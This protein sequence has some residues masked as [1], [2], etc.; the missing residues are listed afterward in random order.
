MKNIVGT[1]V[2]AGNINVRGGEKTRIH[3]AAYGVLMDMLSGIYENAAEA[4]LREY[5]VNGWDEHRKHGVERPVEVTLPTLLQPTLEI[6]DYARGIPL[7]GVYVVNDNGERV[8]VER[9][10]ME[11]FGEYGNSGKRDSDEEVGGFGIGS[12]AAFALGQ[13]FIVNGY[14]DGHG[15]TVL[16]TLNEDGTGTKTVMWEGPT[17]EPN[18]VKVSLGV[19][20]VEGMRASARRFFSFWNEGDVVVDYGEGFETPA[21][22][23]DT[24][25]QV[26]DEIFLNT[27]GR[28]E[29]YAVMGPVTYPIS[30]HILD[31]VSRYLDDQG[32]GEVSNLPL[33]L[34]DSSTDMYVRVPIGG[35][36][37]APSREA[38]RDKDRTVHTI[39]AVFYGLHQDS[40]VKIQNEV[41]AAPSFFAAARAFEE[42]NESL[43][44]FKVSRKAVTWHGRNIHSQVPVDLVNYHLVQ[45]SWRSDAK[46]V[47]E[48]PH[49]KVSFAQA[50]ASLVITGISEEQRGSVRRFAKRFLESNERGIERIF[51]MEGDAASFEWFQVGVPA[52]VRSVDLD[53]WRAMLREIRKTSPRT[54]NEPS[55]TT[56]FT[57][58]SRDLDD[59]DLLSDIIS[60]GLDIVIFHDSASY[61]NA[62]QREV[63]KNHTVVV[64]LGTQ[65]EDALIKRIEA[66]GSVKIAD[67]D[68]LLQ[69][70]KDNA[71]AVV[72]GVTDV[73]KEALGAKAWLESNAGMRRSVQRALTALGQ[74]GAVTNTALLGVEESFALAE[75]F[76]KPMTETRFKQIALARVAAGLQVR[77][78]TLD[79][80]AVEYQ[81]SVD[82]VFEALPLLEV[83]S[84]KQAA[85]R[86]QKHVRVRPDRTFY[87]VSEYRWNSYDEDSHAR[88]LRYLEH[89]LAYVNQH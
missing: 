52:G 42:T 75:E 17:N 18:G 73:E 54:V 70:A 64:L 30:R 4:V 65:S 51:V 62:Y 83:G 7:E 80:M 50:D 44:A 3:E 82:S 89:S 59:R 12:K 57:K 60:E 81:D 22:V 15:F 14:K 49:A 11:V 8:C 74:V 55:Y 31:K 20:D 53:G 79:D 26:N 35:V 46:V 66:D 61:L 21:S 10:A 23:F 24:L 69:Q 6:R 13:Q 38:L 45:K 28:G 37:P 33:R 39:G 19:E 58:A 25:E 16:F 71:Q 27:H 87:Y 5:S 34:V 78:N 41:D 48:E 9:G 67:K 47:G 84:V 56:G 40:V 68:A 85:D 63:L 29:A 32:M 2:N 86:I 36:I 1:A 43:G 76:A 77:I 72:D 88:D